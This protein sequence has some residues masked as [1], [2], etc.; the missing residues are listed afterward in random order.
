MGSNVFIGFQILILPN[1][2][3]GNNVV[4]GA[5]SIVTQDIPDNTV[6]VGNSCHVVGTYDELCE[7]HKKTMKSHPIYSNYHNDKS[8]EG[9]RLM[10]K[11]LDST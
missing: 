8:I 5:G 7:K 11:E 1:V 6:A 9:I 3:F 4:F 2:R 10:Q